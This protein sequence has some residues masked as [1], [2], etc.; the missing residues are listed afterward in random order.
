MKSLIIILLLTFFFQTKTSE[1]F[2][3]Y[4]AGLTNSAL[5]FEKEK[6]GRVAFLGGSI[7]YNPG[8][9]DSV[10]RTIQKRF[11]GPAFEFINS[12][13]PSFG[14]LPDA[15]RLNQDVLSK[16]RID[17]LFVE[18]AVNDRT[19][20]YSGVA[21]VRSM[22]GIVRQARRSNPQIDIIFMYFVDPD[23]IKEY[24]SGITPAEILNH[25][26]VAAYYNIPSVN[27]AKEVTA[28]INNKEFTWEEDFIDLH[29]SLFGQQVYFRSIAQLLDNC[30]GPENIN[31]K[32]LA[33][34]MLPP[35]L[36]PFC[37]DNGKL[38][39]VTRA[40][41]ADGW[42]FDN[43]W[44]P[45][46]KMPTRNGFVKVPMLI[47]TKPGKILQLEFTGTAVGIAV[48][49][50]PDAGIIDFSIDGKEWKS[51][52][53]YTQWSGSLHLPWFL[54]LDDDL[55]EGPHS[56]KMRLGSNKNPASK[57]KT[58][59]IRYFYVNRFEL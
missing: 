22:E 27:L 15:F 58:C 59:R 38:I 2:H 4:R 19:N 44:I 35:K 16:G 18:A 48:A 37:Y 36:D 54:T 49:S 45:D 23:K 5:R 47:G 3:M 39:P 32:D 6:S 12:G 20:G 46:D 41:E 34:Y 11:P 25:E 24:N 7:T 55:E 43:N 30:W 28:R 21:Q 57:G 9:R 8:W 51:L 50:G 26:K 56:L 1:D 52:D 14:S 13:I 33:D 53:L 42:S 10:S 29:P 17:L 31:K 40:N